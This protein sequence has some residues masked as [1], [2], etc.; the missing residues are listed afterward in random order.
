M[1][2]RR[3][4]SGW[5]VAPQR[6]VRAPSRVGSAQY[7]TVSWSALHILMKRPLQRRTDHG[8]QLEIYCNLPFAAVKSAGRSCP[9]GNAPKPKHNSHRRRTITP[10]HGKLFSSDCSISLDLC[11]SKPSSGTVRMIG[12]RRVEF[13]FYISPDNSCSIRMQPLASLWARSHNRMLRRFVLGQ[14]SVFCM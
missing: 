12:A 10:R 11:Y 1:T 14:L 8:R 9:A 7:N 4:S 13:D 3:G 5:H 6:Q 2:W